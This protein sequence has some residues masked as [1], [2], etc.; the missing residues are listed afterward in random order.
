MDFA[1]SGSTARS[2]A[3]GQRD[4]LADPPATAGQ[5]HE[6]V[7]AERRHSSPAAATATTGPGSAGSESLLQRVPRLRIDAHPDHL[8]GGALSRA[9]R[10]R[11]VRSAT[12]RGRG[13]RRRHQ[14]LRGPLAPQGRLPRGC[15]RSRPRRTPRSGP[16]PRVRP[17][18]PGSPAGRPSPPAPTTSTRAR[19]PGVAGMT[20]TSRPSWEQ[21]ARRAPDTPSSGTRSSSRR[22]GYESVASMPGSTTYM[23]SQSAKKS[24][25]TRPGQRSTL[26]VGPTTA[27]ASSLPQ[28][29]DG[30]P[31]GRGEDREPLAGKLGDAQHGALHGVHENHPVGSKHRRHRGDQNGCSHLGESSASSTIPGWPPTSQPRSRP[32][33]TRCWASTSS[34]SRPP[35]RSP[36]PPIWRGGWRPAPTATWATWPRQ[37]TSAA[38]PAT[39]S[40]RHG[41]WCASR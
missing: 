7:A 30:T 14:H 38:T 4:L 13:P 29:H 31:V 40:R 10:S 16:Q 35:T 21:A 32:M 19:A 25:K 24:G 2:R 12:G 15:C 5:D 23:R 34:A 6:G 28:G 33:R 37:R 8:P 18:P 20:A 3:S 22:S 27:V 17:P 9:Q 39:S 1:F 26:P 36:A 11:P 41:A